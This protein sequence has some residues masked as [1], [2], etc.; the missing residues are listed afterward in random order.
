MSPAPFWVGELESARDAY[1]A[2]A[3]DVAREAGP[4]A[5]LD[6]TLREV[7][8]HAH[9]RLYVLLIGDGWTCR[10]GQWTHPHYRA[11]SPLPRPHL[12]TTNSKE[13]A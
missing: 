11:A 5:A 3:V 12:L 7:G 10:A 13:A 8:T 9:A 2:A 1:L 4:A 6:S